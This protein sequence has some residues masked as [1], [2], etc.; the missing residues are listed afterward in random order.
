V[1][2]AHQ[3]LHHVVAKADWSDDAVLAAVRTHVLPS[4]GDI[5]KELLL[6][7]RGRSTA[8]KTRQFYGPLAEIM[9][10]SRQQLSLK[11]ATIDEP[12]WH[13]Y[14]QSAREQ[15]CVHGFMPR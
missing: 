11:R 15:L 2:A 1:Q 6:F 5:G 3:S 10:L 12:L 9:K 7:L 13:N 14:V 8:L 4:I